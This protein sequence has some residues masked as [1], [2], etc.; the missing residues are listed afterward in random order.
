[1]SYWT[2]YAGTAIVL[3]S[4]EFRGMMDK[5][6]ACHPEHA[7]ELEDEHE[8]LYECDREDL[9]W[10]LY[11][12]DP[13]KRFHPV[14][15]SDDTGCDGATFVPYY[16]NGKKN[17]NEFGPDGKLVHEQEYIVYN[18]PVWAFFSER[19]LNS[20]NAFDAMP[21]HSYGE[22][23]SEFKCKLMRYLPNDFDWDGR[24]GMFSYACYA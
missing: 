11:P 20:V 1:M 23:T 16:V 22:L 14:L 6:K 8:S 7:A 19:S 17:L 3:T 15:V 24:I 18:E 12:D 9:L 4:L 10:S 2:G 21:Y 5:Y 13:G